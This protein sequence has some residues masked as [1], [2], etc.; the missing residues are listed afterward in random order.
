MRCMSLFFS[1]CAFHI[2]QRVVH[3]ECHTNAPPSPQILLPTGIHSLKASRYGITYDLAMHYYGAAVSERAVRRR[4]ERFF[5]RQEFE[6]GVKSGGGD[7][8]LSPDSLVPSP[9]SA[10][11][12]DT[13]LFTDS[14]ETPPGDAVMII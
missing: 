4:V 14:P 7:N 5:K 12:G 13:Y 10:T 2:P 8:V 3:F 11:P 6:N 9:S 1:A